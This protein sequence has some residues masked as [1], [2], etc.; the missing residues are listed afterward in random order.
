M[1]IFNDPSGLTFDP[2]LAKVAANANAGLILNHMRGQPETWAKL[3]PMQDPL[4]TVARELDA[5]VSRARHAGVDKARIVIDP[6]LP[7][8]GKRKEQKCGDS[9]APFVNWPVLD[10]PILLIGASRKS[11]LAQATEADTTFATAGA[12]AAAVLNGAHIVR[13]HDVKENCKACLWWRM[14]SRMR[15]E[16]T[17]VVL[18]GERVAALRAG[19]RAGPAQAWALRKRS[20]APRL[21]HCFLEVGPEGGAPYLPLPVEVSRGAE[22]S[23]VENPDEAASEIT[24]E[25]PSEVSEFRIAVAAEAAAKPAPKA[26]RPNRPLVPSQPTSPYSPAA[27]PPARASPRKFSEDREAARGGFKPPVRRPP[28]DSVTGA[29]SGSRAPACGPPS[30]YWSSAR[31]RLSSRRA[32]KATVQTRRRQAFVRAAG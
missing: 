27:R 31:P 4:G 22:A 13:V 32:E 3:P 7:G 5:T 30:G 18:S 12:V 29:R 10:Y 14:K 24:L 11:F 8:F 16:L 17:R 26:E 1:E 2:G 19:P 23:A 28:S 20:V 9:G 21:G 6:G 25:N 15:R